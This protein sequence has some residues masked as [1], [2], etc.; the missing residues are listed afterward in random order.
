MLGTARAS[1]Y[2]WLLVL[3]AAALILFAVRPA[4]SEDYG[5]GLAMIAVVLGAAAVC[6]ALVMVSLTSYFLAW[7][8][9]QPFRARDRL[10]VLISFIGLAAF[11]WPVSWLVDG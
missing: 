1:T 4:Q 11:A 6:L 10:F 5:S 2:S 8:R 7:R 9:A 3:A